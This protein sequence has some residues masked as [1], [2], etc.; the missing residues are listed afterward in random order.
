MTAQYLAKYARR[1]A[2]VLLGF[3][4]GGVW[5]CPAEAQTTP[6]DVQDLLDRFDGR[7]GEVR[8]LVEASRN[9]E[10]DRLLRSAITLRGQAEDALRGGQVDRA[11]NL[12][13][14]AL[15]MLDKA[16]RQ[17]QTGGGT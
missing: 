9:P 4:L 15:E 16:Q 5:F 14:R 10:A 11:F 1:A 17:A 6:Q 13:S 8:D 7:V 2:S 12:A 3:A